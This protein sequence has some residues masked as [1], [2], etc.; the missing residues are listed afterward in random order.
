MP[1]SDYSKTFENR[2]VIN[3]LKVEDSGDYE[4]YLQDGRSNLVRLYV[5]D[6]THTQTDEE[7][8][9]INQEDEEQRNRDEEERRHREEEERRNRDEEERR[10]RE[11]E[12]RRHQEE[13]ARR[14]H[15]DENSQNNHSLSKI[16]F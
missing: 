12:H 11:E 7:Q 10:H 3:D 14:R 2:L 16:I 9:Q 5:R 15:Q 6:V 1:L 4:C 8:T 13:E